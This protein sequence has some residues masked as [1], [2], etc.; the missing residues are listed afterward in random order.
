[1]M[2]L[3]PQ[4][5]SSFSLNWLYVV[6]TSTMGTLGYSFLNLVQN[7]LMSIPDFS[8]LWIITPSAPAAMYALA[9]SS[10][11]STECPAMMLSRRAMIM[12][13]L[14]TWAF[15]PARI[16][17]QKSSTGARVCST[18]V[19]KREFLLRPILSSMMTADIPLRSR[20]RTVNTKCSGL[21]PVSPS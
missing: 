16:F 15:F 1:M 12:N 20:V 10:A 7:S 2:M 11:S 9:R 3:A 6:G 17:S 19:P 21:P 8:L 18:S 13:S 14:V 5:W 4:S